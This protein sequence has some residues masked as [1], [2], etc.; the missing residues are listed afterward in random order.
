MP[1]DAWLFVWDFGRP[2]LPSKHG[3]QSFVLLAGMPAAAV[4]GPTSRRW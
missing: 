2:R 4:A 1:G 3:A